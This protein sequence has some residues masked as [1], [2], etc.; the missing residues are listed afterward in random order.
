MPNFVGLYQYSHFG[1]RVH[2]LKMMISIGGHFVFLFLMSERR[3][4]GHC[5]FFSIQ[6]HPL[7]L[8]LFKI[9]KLLVKMAS[10]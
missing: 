6:H 8:G 10:F 9:I 3:H 4:L 1:E 2:G 7:R 5:Y